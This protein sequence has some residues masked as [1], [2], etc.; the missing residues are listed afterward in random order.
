MEDGIEM[1][2]TTLYDR[3]SDN[4]KYIMNNEKKQYVYIYVPKY[5]ELSS[6]RIT[7]DREEAF[8]L[9]IN[10][11]GTLR[12]FYKDPITKTY[13]PTYTPFSIFSLQ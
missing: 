10:K 4:Q 8:K 6:C 13:I 1:Y 5:G 12:I 3:I 7:H 11:S 9:A 2:R